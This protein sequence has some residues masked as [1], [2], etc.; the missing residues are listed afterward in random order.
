MSPLRDALIYA[1]SLSPDIRTED[2][3]RESVVLPILSA[4]GYDTGSTQD[5]VR[6]RS[7]ARQA[8]NLRAGTN[9]HN[10]FPDLVL[11]VL[12]TPVWVLEVKAPH[13]DI[14][15][16]VPTEQLRNYMRSIGGRCRWGALTNGSTWS[17]YRLFHDEP[18][19]MFTTS[20]TEL[21]ASPRMTGVFGR[22]FSPSRTYLREKSV[23]D[24]LA[25]YMAGDWNIRN[26]CMAYLSDLPAWKKVSLRGALDGWFRGAS[27]RERSLPGIIMADDD[28]VV[29][30]I[31]DNALSDSSDT[32][33]DTF[34]T[35][36]RSG[37]QKRPYRAPFSLAQATPDGWFSKIL[38]LQM[39]ASL[40]R[41]LQSSG[42]VALI[43]R[44]LRLLRYDEDAMVRRF[45][46]FADARIVT[47]FPF[48]VFTHRPRFET[49]QAAIEESLISA[50]IRLAND[51]TYS[52]EARTS[53]LDSI[54]QSKLDRGHVETVAGAR[55]ADL[56]I[57]LKTG[58]MEAGDP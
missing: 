7:I 6:G 28:E 44:Q 56:Y 49:N 40:P 38:Y 50:S 54:R 33:R 9:R 19:L 23:G 4:L 18:R 45:A 26:V 22:L 30:R 8:R 42:N 13:I 31:F 1:A 21:V 48:A 24:I 34:Y 29:G 37:A 10:I 55:S 12:G 20:L 2:G 32:V 25:V 57:S 53:A 52:V 16:S 39:L 17:A 51:E 3:V 47:P 15:A 27:N 5:V 36:I 41:H 43:E 58:G 35:I 14:S 46:D 11:E